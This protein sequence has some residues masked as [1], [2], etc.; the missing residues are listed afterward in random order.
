MPAGHV[1]ETGVK[2]IR[3]GR[4]KQNRIELAFV[5]TTTSMEDKYEESSSFAY[6]IDVRGEKPQALFRPEWKKDA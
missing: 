1:N 6:E 3:E 5:L 2:N 4:Y